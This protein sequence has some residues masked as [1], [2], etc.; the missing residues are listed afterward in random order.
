MANEVTWKN[1]E[2]NDQ[3]GEMSQVYIAKLKRKLKKKK[4]QFRGPTV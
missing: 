2:I 3:I 1:L 4:R